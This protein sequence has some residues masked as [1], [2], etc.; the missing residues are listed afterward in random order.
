MITVD[1]FDKQGKSNITLESFF[2]KKRKIY[3]EGEINNESAME[4]IK[5]IEYLNEVSQDDIYLIINSSGGSVAAGMAI[6]DV[7]QQSHADIVTIGLGFAASMGAFL[8]AAG[9]K[10]KRYSYLHC[11]IMVHQVIAGMQGGMNDITSNFHRIQKTNDMLTQIFADNTSHS[12]AEM[13]QINNHDNYL[14]SHEAK[15]LHI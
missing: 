4:V 1:S 3:L 15:Q 14:S 6:Y 13:E 7:M 8:L 2:L 12:F 10:G 5:Q 9:T 11:E